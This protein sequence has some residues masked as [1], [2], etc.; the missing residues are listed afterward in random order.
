MNKRIQIRHALSTVCACAALTLLPVRGVLANDNN[1]SSEDEGSQSQIRRGYEI[2]PVTLNLAG[3][4]RALVG[5]G[6][7]IVNTSGVTIA[8]HTRPTCPEMIPSL[9]SQS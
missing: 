8:T 1:H 6:S 5:L 3:K 7:Y 4:N 2:N 9:G